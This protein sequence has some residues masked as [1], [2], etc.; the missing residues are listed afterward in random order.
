MTSRPPSCAAIAPTSPPALEGRIAAQ[1]R[2]EAVLDGVAGPT[3]TAA[4]DP[5]ADCPTAV[6]GP[7]E[8]VVPGFDVLD[9]LGE[10]GMGTVYQARDR[11]LKRLVG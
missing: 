9:R 11:R 8:F 1:R 6:I 4:G 10:G 2:M 7:S 3:R 5:G